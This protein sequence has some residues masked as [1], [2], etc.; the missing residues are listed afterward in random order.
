MQVC[1][2][3]VLGYGL[4]PVL[5]NLNFLFVSSFSCVTFKEPVKKIIDVCCM[6]CVCWCGILLSVPPPVL[7]I[8]WLSVLSSWCKGD[9]C[10]V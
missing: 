7:K 1:E 4:L 2:S 8:L 3:S 5:S 9:M 10:Y 6:F